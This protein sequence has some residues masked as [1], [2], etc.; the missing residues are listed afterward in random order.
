M[1]TASTEQGDLSA[2][3][4]GSA[5][6]FETLNVN[7]R[8]QMT[9]GRYGSSL[10]TN[11]GY[12]NYGFPTFTSTGSF[13]Y[14]S[15][16]FNSVT[17]NL[18]SR[19]NPIQN[20]ISENFEY[21]NLN[22][23]DRVY[24]GG[25]TLLDMTYESNKGGI[26]LKSDV[27]TLNYGL[28]G[29][30]YV[31]SSINPSTGLTPNVLDSVTY[32]SFESVNTLSEDTYKALFTYNSD[33]ERAKM[34]VQQNNSDI[35]TRWYPN[36]RYIKETAGGVTKEYTFIGGDA[37][38]AP[39]VAI[40]QNGTTTYYNLLRDHLGSITRVV[41]ASNN[42][43]VAEYS[44]DAWGR[45]RDKTTWVN[46]A[47]GSEP[48]L[49]IAGRGFT[50]HEHLPWFNLINMNGR[51]YDPLTGQFLSADNYVQ[52]PGFTQSFNRYG[53]C[54]NNPLKY[55]DPSGEKI[56]WKP[57][58][59]F[60]F[61]LDPY[62]VSI[63]VAATA[64]T[65]G[66]SLI[67]T[68]ATFHGTMLSIDLT[69]SLFLS[70]PQKAAERFDNAID[71]ELVMFQYDKDYRGKGDVWNDIWQV[72]ARFSPWESS[73]SLFGNGRAHWYNMTGNFEDVHYFHGATVLD[74]KKLDKPGTNLGGSYI[75]VEDYESEDGGIRIAG[76]GNLSE[77]SMTLIHEYG[78]YRQSRIYGPI[79]YFA[80][81][82]NSLFHPDDVEDSHAWF[83]RDASNQGYYYFRDFTT[84]RWGFYDLYGNQGIDY[85]GLLNL[86]FL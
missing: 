81:G 68:S 15:Y 21:D 60:H 65:L 5:T 86:L 10:E 3:G 73:Q 59:T 41:N 71:I 64:G 34:V 37:Y 62:S 29:S 16:E 54:L 35:L 26:V 42:S 7:A 36:S 24:R 57:F 33:N 4:N 43:L 77:F 39:V 58:F 76:N 12:N 52:A 45:M 2:V 51:V 27:G 6:L 32:T 75:A 49:F 70:D 44:Y 53:Y 22:R 13:Q 19:T 83:E 47:P 20:M 55:T 74:V 85:L 9:R 66:A 72:G 40:K 78:H 84:G 46:Y 63:S 79:G 18:N 11:L 38:S 25:T 23:L 82:I 61:L 80:G 28:S 50:G 30:P 48:S 1:G 31:L 14:D 69:S 67:A 56:N 17:G 8:G